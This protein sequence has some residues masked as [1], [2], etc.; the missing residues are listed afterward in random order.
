MCYLS[1]TSCN[2][3]FKALIS[4]LQSTL[5]GSLRKSI[6]IKKQGSLAAQHIDTQTY[7]AHI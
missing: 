5:T 7:V 6:R 3:T 4:C 1:A 2:I